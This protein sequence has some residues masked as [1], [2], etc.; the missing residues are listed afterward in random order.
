MKGGYSISERKKE[1][2]YLA[3]VEKIPSG[4]ERSSFYDDILKEFMNSN[5]KYAAVK[6][7]GKRPSLV[8]YMLKKRIKDNQIKNI[9]VMQRSNKVYLARIE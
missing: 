1:L 3:P 8:A 2:R 6:D 5:L 9:A 7:L 4:R